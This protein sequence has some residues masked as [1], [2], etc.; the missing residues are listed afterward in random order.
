MTGAGISISAGVPDFRS[1]N[2]VFFE[3]IKNKYNFETPEEFFSLNTF[4][5]NPE[6]LYDFIRVIFLQKDY[7][8]TSTHVKRIYI[9]II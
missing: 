3:E 8:P 2:D 9:I 6:F 7:F 5:K 4:N 1:K